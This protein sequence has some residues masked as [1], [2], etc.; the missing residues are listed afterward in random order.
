MLHHLQCP[1]ANDKGWLQVSPLIIQG[2]FGL[3]FFFFFFFGASGTSLVG[4]WGGVVCKTSICKVLYFKIN[5]QKNIRI[6]NRKNYI[7]R[8]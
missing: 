1:I 7:L 5:L 4:V 3:N 8:N 6:K 2:H